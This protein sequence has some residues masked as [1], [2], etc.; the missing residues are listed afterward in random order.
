MKELQK[1]KP[2]R[3]GNYDYSQGGCHFVTIC[4]GDRHELL[5]EQTP[6]AGTRNA[7]PLLSEIGD[8]VCEA[9]ENIPLIYESV[10]VDTYV[11]MP[12]HVHLLLVFGDYFG[13]A[14]GAPAISTVINKIKG[15]VS[16][17]TGLS[18]WEKQFNDH[19]IQ[20][21]DDYIYIWQC[22]DKNPANWQDD[23]FYPK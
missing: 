8:V 5:W 2:N 16:K 4:T 1:R 10:T 22:I 11:I 21:E 6:A 15:Y 23:C 17:Q 14:A 18:I 9:I 3:R 19:V 20:S 12:N 7:R 13:L